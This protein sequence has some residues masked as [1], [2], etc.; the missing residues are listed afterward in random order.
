MLV[1]PFIVEL[2]FPLE[3]DVPLL[4]EDEPEDEE[5]PPLDEPPELDDDPPLELWFD[6][7]PSAKAGVAVQ[8]PTA[9]A[10][11]AISCFF[12]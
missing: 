5:P 12:I 7:K 3:D 8:S 1:S 4:P 6:E 2:E 10:K 11:P 9:T